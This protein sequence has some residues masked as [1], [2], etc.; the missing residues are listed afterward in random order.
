MIHGRYQRP[1]RHGGP[2]SIN[3][4]SFGTDGD[5]LGSASIARVSVGRRKNLVM[6][7]VDTFQRIFK[8]LAA[9]EC[10]SCG[11]V[12]GSVSRAEI[13]TGSGEPS[14]TAVILVE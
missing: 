13:Q 2:P 7:V 1:W 10:E 4:I 6:A 9:L 8:L 11:K 3:Q 14:A 12:T 5:L